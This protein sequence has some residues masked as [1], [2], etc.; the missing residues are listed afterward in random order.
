MV[1]NL[2]TNAGDAGDMSLI[3]GLGGSSGIG[4]GNSF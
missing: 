4:N 3:L 2:R 1:K